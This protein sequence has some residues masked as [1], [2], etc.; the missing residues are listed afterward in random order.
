MTLRPSDYALLAKDAYTTKNDSES[1]VLDGIQYR[2][3]DRVDNSPTGFQA[4]AYRRDDTF[5]VVIAYRGT[6]FDRE[7]VKDGLADTSMV[8]TG[9]N[10]QEREAERFTDRV[11]H[12][13]RTD[14]EIS[15][16]PFDVTVTGHSLGGTLAEISASKF[17]LRGQTFNAYG[18]A[19]LGDGVPAGGHQVIDHVRAGDPVS[20]AAPH[21]GEVRTYAVQE[22]ISAL[23]VAGYDH[24]QGLQNFRTVSA[25]NFDAHGIENFVP[26]N[27]LLG[28]S[29]MTP[30]NEERYRIYQPMVDAY[31]GDIQE[32]RKHTSVAWEARQ[33]VTDSV[34][35]GAH[36]VEEASMDV[37]RSAAFTLGTGGSQLVG[38]TRDF[39]GETRREFTDGLE[40]LGETASR[41]GRD[42]R[43]VAIVTLSAA[44]VAEMINDSKHGSREQGKLVAPVRIDHADNPDHA[45]FK[46]ARNG[47]Y[48][49]DAQQGREPDRLSDN[50]AGALTV[51]ARR[52]GLS[53]IDHV[54]L[55]DDADRAYAMQ[56]EFNSPFKR[57]AEVQTELGI[58]ASLDQSSA[59]LQALRAQQVAHPVQDQQPNVV[60]QAKTGPSQSM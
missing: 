51:E 12:R 38:D 54:V 39:L 30:L 22:D 32:I 3:L 34:A 60:T 46:Q 53:Q 40:Y 45:L 52:S 42:M 29:I 48:R 15:G 58:S 18:A 41:A 20:A 16:R 2:I 49:L 33:V 17:G 55:S 57:V 6:E 8:V 56:G 27:K 11:L 9:V 5:E 23:V 50:L 35:R 43:D 47:V 31:R 44:P 7:S 13:A 14:A 36:A 59:A 37:G 1:V 10:I 21:F 19:G 26:G 28:E 24:E 25:I 4:T